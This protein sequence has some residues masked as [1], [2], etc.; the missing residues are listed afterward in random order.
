[1]PNWHALG[2]GSTSRGV[3]GRSMKARA[4]D[5]PP[6]T[7]VFSLGFLGFSVFSLPQIYRS[8]N[9]FSPKD[10][11]ALYPSASKLNN[12]T[13]RFLFFPHPFP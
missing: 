3:S 5:F 13:P 8:T 7:T 12:K 4:G 1:M 10:L 9:V 2:A 11:C 6:L